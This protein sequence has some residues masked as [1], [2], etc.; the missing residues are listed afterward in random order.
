MVTHTNDHRRNGKIN[1]VK[2]NGNEDL[3]KKWN[4]IQN[5]NFLC[6]IGQ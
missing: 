4:R 6:H 5:L 2:E 3:N 1:E